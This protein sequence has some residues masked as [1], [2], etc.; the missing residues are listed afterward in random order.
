MTSMGC[1]RDIVEHVYFLCVG[2]CVYREV[3][4]RS[5]GR[6]GSLRIGSNYSGSGEVNVSLRSR[7]RKQ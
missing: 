5:K 4:L 1:A 6:A 3:L 7:K 2:V